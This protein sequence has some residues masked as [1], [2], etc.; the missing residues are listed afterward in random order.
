MAGPRLLREFAAAYPDA[1]FAEIGANDG[2][3]HDFLRP[4]VLEGRWRGV[5]VE[6]VPYVFER[7]EANYGTLDRV[8]L[9][10]V[11]VGAGDGTQP[12]YHLAQVADYR[13]EGLPQWYDG[14]G[15]FSREEVLSHQE[16]IPDIA[17]RL[18]ET[19]V[20]VVTLDTLCRRNGIER[21][22]LLLV[23]TEGHDWEIL[24][25][26]D[27]G[28]QTPRVVVY[29]HY[30]LSEADRR[31]ARELLREQGYEAMEEHF[32][33]FC[34]DTRQADALTDAWRRLKP[35]VPGVAAYEEA[36]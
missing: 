21:L 28:A 29:E 15:S 5:V 32:D 25:S 1:T 14:I 17:E 31:A 8:V 3:Q 26:V 16:Q 10:N 9:E 30:H 18:V 2:E 20:P 13:S 22:D 27:F 36:G 35:A 19:E 4:L 34:L 23:D 7:L 11:A 24:R 12:F 6:P 33:T